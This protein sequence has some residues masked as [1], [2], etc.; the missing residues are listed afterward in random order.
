MTIF[1]SLTGAVGMSEE[2]SMPGIS[3]ES[4][5]GNHMFLKGQPCS[6]TN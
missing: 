3:A 4:W 2:E 1:A 5:P 6:H